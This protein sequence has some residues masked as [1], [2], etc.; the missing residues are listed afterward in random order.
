[1]VDPNQQS[2]ADID[3]ELST[4]IQ[5]RLIEKLSESEKRYRTLIENLKEVV[6]EC[7][8]SGE[9]TLLNRAW[10]VTLGYP[11]KSSLGKSPQE[12]LVPED[13]TVWIQALE[14]PTDVQGLC[15]ELRFLNQDGGV[16]WLELSLISKLNHGE[17]VFSGSL[18]NITDR[19]QAALSLE[20]INI[21]LEG[22]VQ[23]RT[24]DLTQANEKL[25]KTLDE[26]KETQ[27]QLIQA[28][29]MSSLGKLVGGLAHEINNPTHFI[30]GNMFHLE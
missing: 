14:M 12:F 21:A 29:K 7:N 13:R 28:E 19:K 17:K 6:F 8:A 16:V 1:M 25:K 26:L 30:H 27:T 11:I 4:Q 18:I 9:F 24:Q 20:S 15:S 22:R 2:Q 23:E 3:N 5:Y 10:T